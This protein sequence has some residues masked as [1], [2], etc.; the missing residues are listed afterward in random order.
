MEIPL[1]WAHPKEDPILS[2]SLGYQTET[3]IYTG[4]IKNEHSSDLILSVSLLAS[5]EIKSDQFC[6]YR[7]VFRKS[8]WM[9]LDI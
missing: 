7:N 6:H 1:I 9:C 3:V 2:L 8:T 4:T 5:G